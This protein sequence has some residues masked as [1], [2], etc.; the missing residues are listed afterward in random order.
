MN[1][2]ML[3]QLGRADFLERVR[4]Y[5]FVVLLGVIAAATFLFVPPDDAGYIILDL[6]GARGIQNSAWIGGTVGLMAAS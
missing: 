2:G 3:W 6:D 4:G 5:R 1:A